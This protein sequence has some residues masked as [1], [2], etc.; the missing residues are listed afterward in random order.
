MSDNSDSYTNG[1]NQ[2]SFGNSDNTAGDSPDDWQSWDWH[3]IERA[4]LG[5]TAMTTAA[6]QATA[7]GVADPDSLQAAS[8]IFYNVQQTLQSVGDDLVQQA[9][10]LAGQDDSPWQGPAASSFITMVKNFAN[11]IYANVSALQDAAGNSVPDQLLNNANMLQWAQNQVN[12]I[13]SYYANLALKEGA[14]VVDNAVQVHDIP[15]I[16]PMMTGDMMQVMGSLVENY[17]ANNYP[18]AVQP[19]TST[20]NG[21][22]NL[23]LNPNLNPNAGPNYSPNFNPNYNPNFNPNIQIPN[24]AP[25]KYPNIQI[26][27]Y[28]DLNNIPNLNT[29]TPNADLNSNIPSDSDLTGSPNLNSGPNLQDSPEAAF[30]STGAPNLT[31]SPN[32]G[33]DL[34]SQDPSLGATPN[35]TSDSGD[36]TPISSLPLTSDD[37]VDDGTP[38][39]GALNPAMDE[40]LNPSSQ[41]T[42][43]LTSSDPALADD[44]GDDLSSPSLDSSPLGDETGDASEGGM[45]Y[46]P[47]SGAGAGSPSLT[48]EP[49]D[50]SGLLGD[51]DPFS[52][53]SPLTSDDVGSDT[54]A[55]PGTSAADDGLGADGMPYMPGSSAG[56]G[57]PSLSS[58][59][60]DAS[61]L[62]GDTDPFTTTSP[63]TSDELGS[64][65][66]AAPGTS[67]ADEGLGA[68]GMPYMPGSGA[69]AGS[70]SLSSDP[71][72][73]SGLLGDTDPFSSTS[74]LTSDELG[75]ETGAAPETSAAESGLGADGMPYMP[76]SGA[77]AGSQTSSSDPSDA[78]GL[79]EGESEPWAESE[80][81]ASDELGSADG[82][83]P[84]AAVGAAEEGL[85]ADGM[86]YMP[87]SGAGAGSQASSS[88][89]SDA[90]GLLEGESEPW[91]ESEQSADGEIGS[92]DGAAAV[93]AEA[94]EMPFMPGTGGTGQA[95][96]AQAE[97]SPDSSGLLVEHD[98]SWTEGEQEHS[99]E[100]GSNEGAVA[101]GVAEAAWVAAG[102]AVA[103]A[104]SSA[105]DEAEYAERTEPD[106]AQYEVAEFD[107]PESYEEEPEEPDGVPRVPMIGADGSDDDMSSWDLA[108]AAADAA[109][110]TLG[111]WA[112]RRRGADDDDEV[113]ARIVSSEQ[114]A[115]LGEDAALPSVDEEADGLPG[116]V[117]WRPN[118]E[119]GGPAESARVSSG[120]LRSGA[121][122]KDYDPVAAAKAAAEAAEAAEAERVAAQEA[123][124][125]DKRQRSTADLLTQ[126]RDMWGGPR[127]DWDAL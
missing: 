127:P 87:A 61:G 114:E 49:S 81:S 78:S 31:G 40:A 44:A 76:A 106:G 103:E 25:P 55:A 72:D 26:P 97:E 30:Q 89:P 58:E 109:L 5:G 85:G 23:N 83:T 28:S 51:T 15:S 62:L 45:P 125:E 79:L 102:A 48:S 105:D 63:L 52:T 65:T 16:P 41:A 6:E 108:G 10:L 96:A 94:E 17:K 32:L 57:S 123:E 29:N 67:A 84:V 7:A 59:P 3:A 68:D 18:D 19:T 13:D 66:G 69:G 39:Y 91:A 93:P 12:Y 113:F 122:P 75:S 33:N 73:A 2:S 54:G 34:E 99:E 101:V 124:E 11:D 64:D 20:P 60:S 88:D 35:L 8:Q 27:N 92:T 82:A 21:N 100:V 121:P 111:A 120:L 110:F 71:S 4:V 14:S 1:P 37:G 77:G 80:Q 112:T 118:R 86:P 98:E 22:T 115:W 38:D 50:A 70:P 42:P 95:A 104:G 116:A 74:P 56:A 46:M 43:D 36:D 90:S 53:T 9:S 107:E 24:Y 47:G 126:E 117:T 119:L